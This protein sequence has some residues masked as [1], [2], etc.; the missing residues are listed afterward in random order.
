MMKKILLI[1][2]ALSSVRVASAAMT[3]TQKAQALLCS[4]RA[5]KTT[6]GMIPFYLSSAADTMIS[7][8]D[9]NKKKAGE[10]IKVLTSNDYL[11]DAI[12]KKLGGVS[13]QHNIFKEV[14]QPQCKAMVAKLCVVGD[15]CE[16]TGKI[17]GLIAAL[18]NRMTCP[19]TIC[20]ELIPNLINAVA[21]KVPSVGNTLSSALMAIYNVVG[22]V[23]CIPTLKD[24]LG[25]TMVKGR[26]IF[27]SESIDATTCKPKGDPKEVADALG[28]S[29]E[30]LDDLFGDEDLFGEE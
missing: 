26:P 25:S 19:G 1:L 18:R 16:K 24:K 5:P 13:V 27:D 14:F 20:N 8:G 6:P 10:I 29:E 11:P 15:V 21:K 17:A 22:P 28:V 3:N 4:M 9:E 23:V 2:V 12:K 30:D 7:S